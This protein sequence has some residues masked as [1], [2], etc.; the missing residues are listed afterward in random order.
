[1][2]D[3]RSGAGAQGS[4]PP[5]A[6]KWLAALA[7]SAIL[8]PGLKLRDIEGVER[9]PLKVEKGRLQALF[10]ISRDCPISNRYSPEIR[11]ICE[12]HSPRGL[13]CALVYVD[14]DLRDA[15]AAKHARDYGHDAWPKFVDRTRALVAATG[16]TV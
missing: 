9:Q 12:G 2:H 14:K 13:E 6:M 8:H 15:D 16:A 3:G 11:R 1:A 7:L 10:F 4:N 5:R